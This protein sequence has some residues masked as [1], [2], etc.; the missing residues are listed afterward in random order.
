MSKAFA[1]AGVVGA[2]CSCSALAAT[3]LFGA[4]PVS[5]CL[6]PGEKFV[7]VA[8]CAA[9]GTDPEYAAA[10]YDWM[11]NVNGVDYLLQSRWSN[12]LTTGVTSQGDPTTLT[13]SFPLDTLGGITNGITSQNVLNAKMTQWFGSVAN[14]KAKFRQVFDRWQVLSGLRYIETNDDSAAWGAQGQLGVRGEIRIVAINVD[15][16]NNTLAFT[17]FPNQGG[18]SGEMVFD[19]SENFGSATADFLFFRN[20]C[21]HEAGHGF[22]LNHV[23]PPIATKLMEPFISTSYDGPRHD[24]TRAIQS[25]YGD[26]LE[27]NDTAGTAS[28]LGT[29]TMPFALTNVS[30]NATFVAPDPDFYRMTIGPAA[31]A[32][33]VWVTPIGSTYDSAAQSGASCPSG[34]SINSNIQQDLV[35]AILASDGTTVLAS[36]NATAAGSVEIINGFNFAANGTYYI[37]VTSA[38]LGN[39]QTQIYR[40]DMAAS[41][42]PPCPGDA[43]GD[44]V[45]NFQDLN[46]VLGQF[47]QSGAGLAGDVTGDGTVNFSDL[48]LVLSNFGVSC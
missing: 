30:I 16:G 19:S 13:Y 37:R 45:I 42:L 48:N 9:P 21:A 33:D 7:G 8:M 38:T 23:C 11:R 44:R 39:A 22:G 17:F 36:A 3:P 26:T 35:L 27:N 41:A 6:R 12:T 14:G 28:D 20:V 4:D 47:G 29:P 25:W 1:F 32:R 31:S 34:S 5:S 18:I 43:N 40:L 46:I 24:D 15:G 2:V 10:F